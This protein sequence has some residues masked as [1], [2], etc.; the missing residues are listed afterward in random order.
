MD[1]LFASP[2]ATSSGT[3]V[4]LLLFGKASVI[5]LLIAAPVGPI[6]L[7]C[8]QRTLSH[9]AGIG[10][11][12]GMGA[13]TA[14]A[15]YGAIGAAG[16]TAVIQLF[17]EMS[18]PLAIF[19][20]LFLAWMGVRLVRTPAGNRPAATSKGDGIFAAFGSTLLLT[21][22]NPMTI[23]SFIA[24]F[25]TLAGNQD[26]TSATMATMVVGVF[27]GSALWWLVLTGSVTL[28]RHKIEKSTLILISRAVGV[29]LLSFSGWQ[30]YATLF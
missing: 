16:L 11:A 6:G 19:G 24:V 12:S 23:L 10:V 14:D 18:Q 27:S 1:I 22:A 13:A 29:V 28:V 7:L 4:E 3:V 30:I 21:L 9:G 5:G 2:G 25:A 8:I 20:A 26:P 15:V 17:T